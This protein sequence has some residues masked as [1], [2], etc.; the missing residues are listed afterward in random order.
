MSSEGIRVLQ[1]S[2]F[3]ILGIGM[4][5]LIATPVAVIVGPLVVCAIGVVFLAIAYRVKRDQAKKS[6][7]DLAADL[8]DQQTAE[9]E[10]VR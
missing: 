1:N 5:Y 9:A 3:V 2:G 10:A 7:S 8:T 4:V 6:I